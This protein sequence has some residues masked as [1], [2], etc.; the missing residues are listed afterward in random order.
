MA[1]SQTSE[2][3]SSSQD[4]DVRLEYRGSLCTN[5]DTGLIRGRCRMCFHTLTGKIR[6]RLS[7]QRST[8]A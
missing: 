4:P 8:D 3:A 2:T 7:P 1:M 6:I 5:A